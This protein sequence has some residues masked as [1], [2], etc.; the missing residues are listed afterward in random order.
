[1]IRTWLNRVK[2]ARRWVEALELASKGKFNDALSLVE[3]I[4]KMNVK[5]NASRP[6]KAG[7]ELVVLKASLL[8]SLG[9]YQD[10]LDLITHI[11]QFLNGRTST[12]KDYL[13][14]ISRSLL[15]LQFHAGTHPGPPELESSLR[16]DLNSID[17]KRVPAHLKRK[18][19]LPA[20]PDWKAGVREK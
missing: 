5:R 15:I 8:C 3:K 20:H 17:L 16:K 10:A 7:V 14:G 12:E 13:E 19:P 4:E 1:M 18:F 2:A 9:K 6:T 11:Q